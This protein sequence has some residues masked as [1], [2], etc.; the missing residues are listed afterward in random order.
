MPDH[1]PFADTPIRSVQEFWDR[2]PCNVRHSREPVGSRA[3]FDQ[4]ES[5]KYFVEPH[6][7]GFADFSKWQDKRVLEVGCGIGTDTINFARAGAFVTAVDLSEKSLEIART[8]AL[9]FGVEDRVQFYQ[10]DAENLESLVPIERYDLVYSFGV[11]HHTPNPGLVLAGIRKFMDEDS[12]LKLM[13]YHRR[14]FKVL[15][16]LMTFGRGRFWALDRLVAQ[17]SEAQ[18]GCPVTYAYSKIGATTLLREHGFEVTR[19]SVDHIFPYVISEYIQYRYKK[20]WYI[21]MLPEPIFRLLETKFGWHLCVDARLS[22]QAQVVE[23][24]HA[25][26]LAQTRAGSRLEHSGQ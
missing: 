8:R 9:V 22:S 6:I 14:S 5:R 24:N 1:V 10:A 12:T 25:L 2:R 4:V 26:S 17:H 20:I 13:V 19:K 15:W 3:Y 7:P 11:I 18:N 21:R 23:R 16:I